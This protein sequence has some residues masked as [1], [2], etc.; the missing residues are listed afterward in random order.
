M[1]GLLQTQ[2]VQTS[3]DKLEV[4][5]VLR[6]SKI[7][8]RVEQE[9]AKLVKARLGDDIKM[10]FILTD[11]IPKENNGKTQLVKNKLIE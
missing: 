3:L 8:N 11:S 4:Y 7:R 5:I 10:K 1:E 2:I 9:L 6:D